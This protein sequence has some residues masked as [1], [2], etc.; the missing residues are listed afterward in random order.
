MLLFPLLLFHFALLSIFS[1]LICAEVTIDVFPFVG[2]SFPCPI[3][4][5]VDLEGDVKAAGARA[6]RVTGTAS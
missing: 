5:Q 2:L 4:K 1:I 3:K 6:T